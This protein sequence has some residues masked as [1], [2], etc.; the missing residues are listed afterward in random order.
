MVFSTDDFSIAKLQWTSA[1]DAQWNNAKVATQLAVSINDLNGNSVP[2]GSS[3]A[4]SVID[5]SPV[6]V[7]D[8]NAVLQLLGSCALVSQSHLEVPDS[9]QALTLTLNLKQCVK[10]DQVNVTVTTP[11]ITKTY[12]FSFDDV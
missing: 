1:A 6:P 9:L 8:P 2:T 5:N 4:V 3:I 10:G 11:A 12:T 7:D